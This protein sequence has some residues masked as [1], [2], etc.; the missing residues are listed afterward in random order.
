MNNENRTQ[1]IATA[2]SDFFILSVVLFMVG[3]MYL[4]ALGAFHYVAAV[5][6]LLL[7][8]I[9]ALF[10]AARAY[11]LTHKDVVFGVEDD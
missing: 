11:H 4:E 8:L 6:L 1:G 5:F 7:W 9:V 10:W 3:G 2:T